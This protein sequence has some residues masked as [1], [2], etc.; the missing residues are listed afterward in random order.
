MNSLFLFTGDYSFPSSLVVYLY[1]TFY[2]WSFQSGSVNL[3]GVLRVFPRMINSVVFYLSNSLVVSYFYIFLAVFICFFSFYYFLK[4]FIGI[5]SNFLNILASFLFILNPIFIGNMAKIGLSIAVAMLPLILVCIKRFFDT[6]KSR[7]ILFSALFLNISLIHPFTLVVNLLIALIYLAYKL[8]KKR[9]KFSK[10]IF[11]AIVLSVLLNF[12]IFVAVFCLGTL[13]KGSIL[14]G[15]INDPQKSGSILNLANTGGMLGALSMAKPVFKDFEFYDDSFKMIYI[16]SVWCIYILGLCLLFIKRKYLTKRE[17]KLS[18]LFLVLFLITELFSTGVMFGTD[19]FFSFINSLPGGWAFRSPLKWQLYIPFFLFTFLA[20]QL[21]Q[22]TRSGYKFLIYVP[23]FVFI[24][25]SNIYI[26]NEL[27]NKLLIPKISSGLFN[28]V[29][30]DNKNL[31][32]IEDVVC[33]KYF[34]PEL[35][36]V[37][38]SN[39]VQVKTVS[40]SNFN[41]VVGNNFD[42]I[43]TCGDLNLDNFEP[44]L[45]INNKLLLLNNKNLN[46]QIYAINNL[47][48][49][50]S[51]KNI[52]NKVNFIKNVLTYPA[53]FTS[54]KLLQESAKVKL[55]FENNILFKESIGSISEGTKLY[56]NEKT[57]LSNLY[58]NGDVLTSDMVTLDYKNNNYIEYKT[59]EMNLDNLINNPSFENGLWNNVVSDCHNFDKNPIIKSSLD[60]NI[61]SD[62][63]QSLKLEAERHIACT[64]KILTIRGGGSYQFSFDYQSPNAEHSSYYLGFNDKNKTSISE[65]LDIKNSEW[66][67]FTKTIKVP[68]DATKIAIYVYADSTDGKTNIINRYDNFKLIEVPDL[69][70]AYYL[71][72]EPEIKLFEPK[73]I[74][75]D[76][77]NPTKKLVHIKGATTPFYIAMSESYHDKWQL[78]FN[79]SKINGFFDS[80]IPFVKPDRIPDE[81]HYKLNDFLNAWYVDTDHYCKNNNLCIKN[82]DGSYDIEMTIE[83]FP[84]RWFYLG[85]LI[86]GTTLAGCVGYLGYEGVKSIKRRR[87]NKNEKKN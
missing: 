77:I 32:I 24:F 40:K 36:Q 30:F 45:V 35:N 66:H 56:A 87:K 26:I 69:S 39:N 7:Y 21:K 51:T 86:S 12:S 83:F 78:Q 84:Q 22:Y 79:N 5:K 70:D 34:T 37:L 9:I 14:N 76:L 68:K 53:N 25:G 23:V 52:E 42:F 60:K 18:L 57:H 49:I 72:S 1:K 8:T 31:L 46:P 62:G 50:S 19:T 27:Y 75:F 13:D 82:L 67:T 29:D 20:I 71:V 4:Y 2:L 15:L 28:G 64:S 80:W 63:E 54:D 58:L 10:N 33:N 61:K 44:R 59:Q 41:E 85:L 74:T 43:V 47:Y 16:I 81:Y 38:L 48:E 17:N 55:L 65:D 11:I 73:S 6:E 3:D